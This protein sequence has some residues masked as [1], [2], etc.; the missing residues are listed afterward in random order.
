MAKRRRTPGAGTVV[1]RKNKDGSVT[2]RGAFWGTDGKRHWV[3]AKSKTACEERLREAITDASR[4]MMPPPATLTVEKHLR[5]WLEGIRGEVSRAT[6]DG[7]AR[8]VRY[9]IIPELGRRKL[10]ELSANDIRRLYRKMR[11][12]DLKNRSLEYCHRTLRKALKAALAERKIQFDPSEGIKPLKTPG[13][14]REESKALSPAQ[15][16]ALLDAASG[17]RLEAFYVV[18]IHTG[19]RRG[20]LLGLKWGDV[21]LEAGTVS[22]KRSVDVDGRLKEPKNQASRRTLPLTPQ[23]V[24]A[25]KA[26][27]VRQNEERLKAG[28]KWQ[29]NDLLF[30]NTVGRPENPSNVYLRNFQPLLKRAGLA[31]QG[32]TL[33]SLRHTF[34][35]TLAAKG[36]NPGTAQK[37]LGHSDVRM[38]LA[39]YT[40]ATDDMRNE[41]IGALSGAFL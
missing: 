39:I 41:A 40:H 13:G 2:W 38:T 7:Y 17:D 34:A 36:V 32:F 25:L 26:H 31:N 14:R 9:H 10:K 29:D 15:V 11:D 16:R 8:D 5:E 12:K 19:M 4:G 30:P 18:A 6:Y 23:A 3:S 20:E 27:R 21:D 24:D 1:K 35:T 28:T 33:H 37:L 22:V